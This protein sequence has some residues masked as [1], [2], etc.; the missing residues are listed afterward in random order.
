MRKSSLY[1]AVLVAMLPVAASAQITHIGQAAGRPF[2]HAVKAGD[3]IYLSG[4]IG[5]TA[6]GLAKG[7]DAQ[8]HQAMRNLRDV[9]AK[10]NLTMDS[11][12]KCTI[13]LGDMS[14][15]AAF[16]DIYKSYF[17]DGVYPARSAL[18]VN[19]LALGAELEVECIAYQGPS[20]T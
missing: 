4:Q 16:N 18:G 8:A 19:G 2:S 13:F 1:A 10:Q 11:I 20:G 6:A 3:T 12:V 17:K 7:F 14:K 5:A 9:L 15:W